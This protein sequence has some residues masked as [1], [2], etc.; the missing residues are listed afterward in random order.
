MARG[1]SSSNMERSRTSHPC[2]GHQ[3]KKSK[4]V[5]KEVFVEEPHPPS[6]SP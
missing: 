4:S 1:G 5:S 2:Q 3:K 6:L